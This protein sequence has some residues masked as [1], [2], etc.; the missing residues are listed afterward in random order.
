[1]GSGAFYIVIRKQFVFS[2]HPPAHLKTF[3]EL[4]YIANFSICLQ[5]KE[6]K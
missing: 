5:Y 2:H 1:M 3:H 6:D 4:F